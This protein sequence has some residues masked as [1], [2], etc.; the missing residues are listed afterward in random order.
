MTTLIFLDDER[1]YKDVTWIKYPNFKNIIVVR[2]SLEFKTLVKSFTSFKNIS[3][4]FDHD[5]QDYYEGEEITGY[6]CAKWL[7]DYLYDTKTI[8]SDL[9]MWCHSMNPIGKENIEMYIKNYLFVLGDMYEEK[10]N[11]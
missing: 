8:Y 4:S 5:I 6:D 2:N 1:E 11:V 10:H 3:F 7:L 9:Q